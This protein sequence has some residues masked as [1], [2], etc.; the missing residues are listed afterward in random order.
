MLVLGVCAWLAYQAI[1]SRRGKDQVRDNKAASDE[2][3]TTSPTDA[4]KAAQAS[5]KSPATP[6]GEI[7]LEAKGYIIPAHQSLVSPKVS[8][9]IVALMIEEGKRF[10]AGDMLAVIES[11]EYQYDL[12]RALAAEQAAGARW[13]E[14]QRRLKAMELEVNQTQAQID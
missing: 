1:E 5:A 4:P 8:G 11:K 12:D 13:R 2:K 10:A 6:K 3:P 14:A 9:M 7:A